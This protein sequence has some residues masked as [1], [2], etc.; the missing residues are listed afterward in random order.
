MPLPSFS[1]IAGFTLI[2]LT[3]FAAPAISASAPRP[4]HGLDGAADALMRGDFARAA[5][6]ASGAAEKHAAAGDSGGEARARLAAGRAL[7][8]LGRA[9]AA[10]EQL[11]AALASFPKGGGGRA[12]ALILAETGSVYTALGE[13]EEAEK[14]LVRGLE[15]ARAADDAEASA[16]ALCYLGQ[17]EIA[18]S[19]YSKAVEYFESGRRAALSAGAA[20]AA[21]RA[22]VNE[23]R[24]LL[25]D[26]K[27][28][29]ARDAMGVATGYLRSLPDSHERAFGLLEL[30]RLRER[31]AVVFPGGRAADEKAAYELYTEASAT[32]ER[33]GDKRSYSFA[34]GYLAGL[35]RGQGRSKEAMGLVRRAMFAA[36]EAGADDALYLWQ[37]EAGRLSMELGGLDE[38][39][40]YYRLAAATAE[41]I[42]DEITSCRRGSRPSFKEAAGPIFIELVDLLLRK[43]AAIGDDAKAEPYLV[44]ARDMTEKLKEAEIQDYF[45][46]ECLKA[47]REKVTGIE[48]I[49]EDTAVFYAIILPGRTELLVSFADGMKRFTS[50]V[51]EEK[52]TAEIRA[53]R[54]LLEKRTTRQ[55]L[56]HARRLYDWLIRPVEPALERAGVKTLIFVPD[57]ALRTI[58]MAVLHDGR[59]YLVAKYALATTPGFDLTDPR[60][61]DREG[62]RVLLAGLTESVQGF[63]ALENVGDELASIGKEYDTRLLQDSSFL[64]PN[65]E[66]ELEESRY[67]IVHVASHGKFEPQAE[68]SFLLTYDDRLT[69]N[70]LERVV[71]AS[72][73]RDMPVELLTLSA[74]QTAAGDER[75]ALGLAGISIKAGARSA[76]ATLWFVNDQATSELIEEFYRQ[77]KDPSVSKSEA[78]RRAQLRLIGDRRYRHPAYWSPFLLIGNWL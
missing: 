78:L 37:W 16:M 28:D 12:A 65:V 13:M 31:I 38:A 61:I 3:L 57:A 33:I 32:A 22:A 76:L 23:A 6:L 34:A 49:L 48:E 2:T 71:G 55:Y 52:M 7:K 43:A 66:K 56:P 19:G 45:N 14:Y 11:K 44:E 40:G 26:G 67:S 68:D 58:P 1:R 72:Q 75:A 46:D 25:L 64:A 62:A 24:A 21:A 54:R 53:L 60:P 47:A 29:K 74:C 4:G 36:Q 42:R 30:G 41:S 17:F 59:E 50:H 15:A 39:I 8:L 70:R 73:Y 9:T 18:R 77:F 10:A 27:T 63:P 51:T 20:Q 5:S 69:M 35:Y